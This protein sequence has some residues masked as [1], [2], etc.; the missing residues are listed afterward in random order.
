MNPTGSV[1][2][3]PMWC[4]LRC[5]IASFVLASHSSLRSAMPYWARALYEARARSCRSYSSQVA[6]PSSEALYPI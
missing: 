2:R 4:G 5:G 1:S 6:I 3:P